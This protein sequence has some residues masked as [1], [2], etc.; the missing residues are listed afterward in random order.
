MHQAIRQVSRHHRTTDEP[1]HK[2][3]GSHQASAIHHMICRASPYCRATYDLSLKPLPAGAADIEPN[4]FDD[5]RVNALTV[6][7]LGRIVMG[8]VIP[9]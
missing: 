7:E 4:P 6:G 5:F 9:V 8:G 3:L 1:L 2:P